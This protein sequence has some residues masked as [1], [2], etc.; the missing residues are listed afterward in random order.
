LVGGSW[1]LTH[2]DGK[3]ESFIDIRRKVGNQIVRAYLLKPLL[4]SA[5]VQTIDVTMRGPKSEFQ[6]FAK[7]IVVSTMHN[8]QV[9]KLLAESGVYENVRIV[10]VDSQ[11]IEKLQA[12]DIVALFTAA[13]TEP[14]SHDSLLIISHDSAVR[15]GSD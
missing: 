10:G 6:D 1:N 11:S 15:A 14:E 3:V 5:R 9:V 2:R 7:F 13:L 8:G 12:D 4:A